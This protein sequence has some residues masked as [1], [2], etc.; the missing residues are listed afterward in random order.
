MSENEKQEQLAELI[1]DETKVLPLSQIDAQM[2][3]AYKL[4]KEAKAQ[5]EPEAQKEKENTQEQANT[6]DSE[7]EKEEAIPTHT[8]SPLTLEEKRR[9]QRMSKMTIEERRKLQ[10]ENPKALERKPL[11]LQYVK[12]ANRID[13]S[14]MAL[15]VIAELLNFYV[16]F[17]M[18][19]YFKIVTVICTFVAITMLLIG[20]LLVTAKKRKIGFVCNGIVLVMLLIGG[21]IA[22][23][24]A[25]FYHKVFA[26]TE[27]ETVMIVAK[28]DADISASSDFN[29]K[30]LA[31]VK[32]ETQANEFVEQLLADKN[33]L[34]CLTQE[35]YSYQDA[36][37]SL[38][39]NKSDIMVYTPQMEQRFREYDIDSRSNIKVLFERER[40][41]EAVKA[42][43]VNIKREAFT[44]L[45]SGTDL[46]SGNHNEKGS[47]DVAVL[48]T[49][50]PKTKKMLL[51]TIPHE[52]RIALTCANNKQT[53]LGNAGAYG[54]IGC[55]VDSLEKL[56]GITI[57]YY[58][59]INLK[60]IMDTVDVLDGITINSDSAYCTTYKDRYNVEQ[61][62]CFHQGENRID[63]AQAL[64]YSRMNQLSNSDKIKRERHQMEV[65]RAIGDELSHSLSMS[66]A[67]K[68][69]TVAENH[70]TT[71]FSST[72]I[73]SLIQLLKAIKVRD[74]YV[75]EG[76]ML[77][78]KD[79][80]TNES[81]T[82]FYPDNGQVKL[83][84]QR[85]QDIIEEK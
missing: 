75:L 20:C 15:L 46:S 31:T 13:Y 62:V 11:F 58:V 18:M 71:N 53:M 35:F 47:T 72:D 16:S 28:G 41:L 59:K 36:Y 26:D 82:Y 38:M 39:N 57:N 25:R 27:V 7:K 34:G 69:L 17:Q 52:S 19:R 67:N 44:I 84:K 30:K 12:Q 8:I 80:I 64:L 37:N 23:R 61:Q 43:K 1:T 9:Q 40:V 78:N 66:T 32:Y 76:E 73:I 65:L 83:V 2:K 54:G 3:D 22:Y 48:A 70:L 68:L 56:Y 24:G 50:N 49:I 63:G 5:K 60:G 33:K 79:E 42:K 81:S 77:E 55:T 6:Q 85:I 51:H 4:L 10:R 14:F 29:N 21:M 74:A 45:I